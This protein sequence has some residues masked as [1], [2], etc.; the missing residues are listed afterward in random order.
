MVA[1]R[2]SVMAADERRENPERHLFIYFHYF[3][4]FFRGTTK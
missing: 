4:A 2:G 3:E 1:P